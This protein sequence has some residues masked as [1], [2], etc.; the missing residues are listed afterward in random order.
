MGKVQF[1]GRAW[2]A[3]RSLEGSLRAAACSSRDWAEQRPQSAP[4]HDRHPVALK[5]Q[6][7]RGAQPLAGHGGGAKLEELEAL[8]GGHHA[9]AL[10]AAVFQLIDGRPRGALLQLRRQG[11]GR[12]ALVGNRSSQ[13]AAQTGGRIDHPSLPASPPS[14]LAAVGPVVDLDAAL[15]LDEVL[16]G[17]PRHD[18]AA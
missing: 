6:V 17:R 11:E 1:G 18:P 4:H 16:L 8:G 9:Q 15:V 5:V 7:E 14:H 12:G 2:S 13:A 10:A 3:G